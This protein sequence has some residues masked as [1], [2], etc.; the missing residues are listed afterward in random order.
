MIARF[1][2]QRKLTSHWSG[3]EVSMPLIV[4]LCGFEVVCRAAQFRRSAAN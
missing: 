2:Q 3:R 1:F 4:S